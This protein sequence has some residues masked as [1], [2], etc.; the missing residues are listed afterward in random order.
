MP[1]LSKAGCLPSNFYR[2]SQSTLLQFILSEYFAAHSKIEALYSLTSGPESLPKSNIEALQ[3]TIRNLLSSMADA[4]GRSFLDRAVFTWHSNTGC[5]TKLA[6]Y[7]SLWQGKNHAALGLILKKEAHR[8]WLLCL[9]VHRLVGQWRLRAKSE[10]LRE[11]QAIQRVVVK[12]KAIMVK[13]RRA[14][15]NILSF[16]SRDENVVYYMLRHREAVTAVYGSRFIANWLKKSFA[17]LDKAAG[18]LQ[19]RFT[20]R[21][22]DQ[23]VPLIA[24]KIREVKGL[25]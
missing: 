14:L 8:A 16:F 21:G 13:L 4:L 11:L 22:F 24:E 20:K 3:K 1:Q 12:L 10:I 25:A 6:H 15:V 5:L 2:Y 19:R 17:C 23:I 7:C 18:F 9:E